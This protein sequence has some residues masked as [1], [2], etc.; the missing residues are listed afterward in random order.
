M[1]IEYAALGICREEVGKC[2]DGKQ[3]YYQYVWQKSFQCLHL[4]NLL[5]CYE[6]FVVTSASIAGLRQL[7]S[8]GFDERAHFLL[9]HQFV[10]HLLL[11]E[12]LAYLLGFSQ[13][14][15]ERYVAVVQSFCHGG[16]TYGRG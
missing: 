15:R 4:C 2:D 11:G 10:E 6:W 13:S 9:L 3:Q 5:F 8:H 14:E 1:A 12:F 7:Q 16:T